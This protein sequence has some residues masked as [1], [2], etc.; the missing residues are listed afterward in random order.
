MA[1]ATKNLTG[2]DVIEAGST[3]FRTYK[4]V[5]AGGVAHNLTDHTFTAKFRPSVYCDDADAFIGTVAATDNAGGIITIKI[6]DDVTQAYQVR[7]V[8]KAKDGLTGVWTLSSAKGST[9]TDSIGTT[10][11]E[12][13]WIEGT[14]E[15]TLDANY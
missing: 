14:W 15:M 2:A 6:T 9:S 4:L 1:A 11:D 5:N 8:A 3:W 10:G 12:V 13:R 7:A